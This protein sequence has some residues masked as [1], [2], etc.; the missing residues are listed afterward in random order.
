MVLVVPSALEVDV[1]VDHKTQR[2]FHYIGTLY[3]GIYM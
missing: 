2:E 1:D 3:M